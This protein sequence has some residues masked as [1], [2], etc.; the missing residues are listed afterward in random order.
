MSALE[1]S[2]DIGAKD[3]GEQGT[4][5]GSVSPVSMVEERVSCVRVSFVFV[6][7]Y[8]GFGKKKMLHKFPTTT[9]SKQRV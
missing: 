8:W 6:G 2:L 9:S 1:A 4:P 7:N 5:T 3:K